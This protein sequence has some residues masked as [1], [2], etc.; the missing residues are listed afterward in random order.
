MTSVS[1]KFAV[2]EPNSLQ[3]FKQFQIR[4]KIKESHYGYNGHDNMRSYRRNYNKKRE[5]FKCK[6]CFCDYN[7]KQKLLS[8]ILRK[9]VNK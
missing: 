5:V 1:D 9:H 3:V 8:H 4:S 2:P 7:K 6:Y